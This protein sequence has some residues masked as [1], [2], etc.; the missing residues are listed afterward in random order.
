M[1]IHN[2]STSSSNIGT[3]RNKASLDLEINYNY[4]VR[5]NKQQVLVSRFS[6][7]LITNS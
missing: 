2:L 6:Y 7:A 5:Y 1:Y 4:D 3:N